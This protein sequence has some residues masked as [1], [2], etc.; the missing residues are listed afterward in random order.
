MENDAVR[1]IATDWEDIQTFDNRVIAVT[2]F[3]W[4]VLVNSVYNIE[5]NKNDKKCH[6]LTLPFT[7]K[8]LNI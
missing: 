5:I 4:T 3:T 6:F 8:V 2:Q 1:S 7:C